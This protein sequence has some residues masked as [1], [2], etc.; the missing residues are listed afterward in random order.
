M[1]RGDGSY[2]VSGWMPAIE[3]AELLKIALPASRQYQTF[4]GFPL[5]QFGTIPNTVNRR[6]RS[7]GFVAAALFASSAAMNARV[8]SCR[9]N[10]STG[11]KRSA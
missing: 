5:Q 8:A 3:F 10:V 6:E 2:L 11:R 7:Y 1:R 4:A 9:R